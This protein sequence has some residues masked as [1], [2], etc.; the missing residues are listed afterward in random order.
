MSY[1]PEQSH[2]WP[3]Y[4]CPDPTSVYDGLGRPGPPPGIR[5][6]SVD[7]PDMLDALVRGGRLDA[8]LADG[9]LHEYCLCLRY[10]RPLQ[11]DL[12]LHALPLCLKAWQESLFGMGHTDVAKAFHSALGNAPNI[13]S[14]TISDDAARVVADFMRG[15]LIARMSRERTLRKPAGDLSVHTWI[16][17][18]ASYGCI[19]PEVEK[20]FDDWRRLPLVGLS[21]AAIQY[22]SLLAYDDVEHPLFPAWSSSTGGG[23]PKP[24]D[25]ATEDGDSPTWLPENIKALAESLSVDGVQQWVCAAAQQ[26]AGHTEHQLADLVAE[27]VG[28]Q[29]YRVESRIVDLVH[30]M[31]SREAYKYW[32][33]SYGMSGR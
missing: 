16:A 30:H 10:V 14:T 2:P 12:M 15:S 5:Q 29:P 8:P 26:L 3:V 33:D 13:I 28:L 9:P 7:A 6:G 24:W 27:D 25:Y 19:W 11:R 1:S 21:V 23:A 22:L 31:A 18:F 17:F 32:S 20:I 4:T